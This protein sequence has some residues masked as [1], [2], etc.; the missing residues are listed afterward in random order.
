M[1]PGLPAVFR[2]VWGNLIAYAVIW[3][4]PYIYKKASESWQEYFA[5]WQKREAEHRA[6]TSRRKPGGPGQKPRRTPA[7]APRSPDRPGVPTSPTSATP[8]TVI[9]NVPAAPQ[10][11][12][13]RQETPKP[14]APKPGA[15]LS[16]PKIYRKPLPVPTVPASVP[17]WKRYALLAAPFAPSILDL[18]MPSGGSKRAKYRDPLTVPQD[19]VA[20]YFSTTT[21]LSGGGYFGGSAPGKTCDC[22]PKKKRGKRKK[23]TVCYKGS[24]V[25]RATGITKRKREKIPCQ[26]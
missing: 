3:A 21:N 15:G 12:P 17:A 10:A 13:G 5:R 26:A 7:E 23:R 22:G 24:Y 11:P 18:V 19:Q 20:N 2:G 25:E 8:V 16:V 14:K 1:P 9:V 4:L 6:A